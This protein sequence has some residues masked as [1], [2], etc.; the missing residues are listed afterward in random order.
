MTNYQAYREAVRRWTKKGVRNGFVKISNELDYEIDGI[1][2]GT[3]CVGYTGKTYA[4][5]GAFGGSFTILGKG[6]SW[7]EAF[8]AVDQIKEIN[9]DQ[10]KELLNN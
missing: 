4:G 6:N 3:Y 7:E 9:K 8:A 1:P 10:L 2:V 5:A